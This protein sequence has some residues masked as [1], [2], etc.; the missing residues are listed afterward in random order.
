MAGPIGIA[1]A[2][3]GPSAAAANK[4][5]LQHLRLKDGRLAL[6]FD[7]QGELS[8]KSGRQRVKAPCSA[9]RAAVTLQLTASQRGRLA[10]GA[11]VRLRTRIADARGAVSLPLK[12]ALPVKGGMARASLSGGVWPAVNANSITDGANAQCIAAPPSDWSG[13][14]ARRQV[15]IESN[16]ATFG[17]PV[18]TR[19]RWTAWVE[20]FNPANSVLSWVQGYTYSHVAW[21][22]R[23]AAAVFTNNGTPMYYRPAIQ[24]VG[25][26]WNYA[27]IM[28]F[29]GPLASPFYAY[30]TSWCY[31]ARG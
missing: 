29:S 30:P 5:S 14:P 1:S 25:G 22:G 26:D 21:G 10:K 27:R 31:M 12:L 2:D 6:K 18:G 23:G 17:Y 3:G 16:Y 24:V 28:A 15:I 13:E 11:E 7:C 19:L 9:G 20:T 4:P 8:V